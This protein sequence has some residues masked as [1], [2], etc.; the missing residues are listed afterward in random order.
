[1]PLRSLSEILIFLQSI[2]HE[3]TGLPP[4]YQ[5]IQMLNPAEMK[6]VRDFAKKEAAALQALK[7]AGENQPAQSTAVANAWRDF[8]ITHRARLRDLYLA[9]GIEVNAA[10]A[11]FSAP[12]ATSD[13]DRRAIASEGLASWGRR[14]AAN[15]RYRAARQ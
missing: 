3:E 15:Q 4:F 14:E 7:Q 8:Q 5:R 6:A 2:A 11:E 9:L 10:D 1:M 13:A 12:A